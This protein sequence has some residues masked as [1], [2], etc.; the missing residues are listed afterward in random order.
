VEL[1]QRPCLRKLPRERVLASPGPDQQDFHAPS[2]EPLPAGFGALAGR[3]QATSRRPT[4]SAPSEHPLARGA[5]AHEAHRYGE[6]V[7]DECDVA[8]G[9]PR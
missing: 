5:G 3:D 6:G 7:F 1:G 4:R 9:G 2:L 8:P